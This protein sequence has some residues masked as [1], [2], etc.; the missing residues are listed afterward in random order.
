MSYIDGYRKE[1]LK[2]LDAYITE[3]QRNLEAAKRNGDDYLKIS[4]PGATTLLNLLKDAKAKIER[5]AA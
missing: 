5:D 3:G 1:L 4:I 2:N